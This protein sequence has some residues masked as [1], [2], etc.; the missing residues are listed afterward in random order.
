MPTKRFL[1]TDFTRHASLRAQL[2]LTTAGFADA[3]RAG[4]PLG[5]YLSMRRVGIEAISAARW[6]LLLVASMLR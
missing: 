5:I 4:L 2:R 1:P 6:Q 3:A